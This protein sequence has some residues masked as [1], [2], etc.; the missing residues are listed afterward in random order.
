MKRRMRHTWCGATLAL[1]LLGAGA[2]AAQGHEVQATRMVWN[3][4]TS[5][6]RAE[7]VGF[8]GAGSHQ[9][10]VLSTQGFETGAWVLVQPTGDEASASWQLLQVQ[11]LG[12]QRLELS[13]PLPGRARTAR[14]QVRVL[15][16]SQEPEWSATAWLDTPLEGAR[17]SGGV[18]PVEGWAQQDSQVLIFVDGVE[19][20]RLSVDSTGRFEGT[21]ELPPG[22]GNHQLR[23]VTGT[24]EDWRLQPEPVTLERLAPP[25]APVVLEPV[26]G[27]YTNDTTP[28]IRGTAQSGTKVFVTISGA[29]VGSVDV[30]ASGEW[31]LVLTS[32]LADGTYPV[33]VRAQSVEGETSALVSFSFTV[34]TTRPTV[35]FVG[36]LNGSITGSTTVRARF[37][38]NGEAGTFYCSLDDSEFVRCTS[39]RDLTG[40]AD[41]EHVFRVRMT[42]LAGNESERP[43]EARF[44]VDTTPPVLTIK[45]VPP[46]W[47]RETSTL[48]VLDS[49]EESVD[50][51]CTLD[52]TVVSGCSAATGLFNLSEGPH[53]FKARAIDEV[54]NVGPEVSYTWNVDLTPPAVPVLQQPS[55]GALLNS[56]SLDISGTAEPGSTV[57]VLIGGREGCTATADA[58]G[59]WTCRTTSALTTDSYELDLEVQDV[60]GNINDQFEAISFSVDV[61]KPDTFI[62]LP[63]TFITD[64]A[65][66]VTQNANPTFAFRSNEEGVTFECSVDEAAFGSC[67][68]LANGSR[69]FAPGRYT[70]R[71]RARDRAGNVDDSP[72]TETWVYSIYEGSGGG[73]TGCSASG[74]AP[75]LPLVPLLAFLKRRRQRS[76]SREAAVGGLLALLLVFLAGPARAQG[77]DL[78]QYKPA[79]GS[80]DVLGVYSPQ[81]APGLGL[82]AGLSV[83]YAR[84]PLVLRTASNGDFAQSIVSDQ[85]TADVL[86]SISF[87]DHFELGLAL[88][89]T[90][91]WGPESG[92]LGI[93][94]PQN[95]TGTGLGDLRLVPKAVLPLGALSL[96]LA[97]VVSLPTASDQ[98]FLGAGGVGVQPTLMVQWA[99]SEQLRVLANLGA[100]FQ[101]DKQVALLDLNVGNELTY[102]LGAHWSPAADSKLFVQGN[103]EGAF[104]LSNQ[105]SNPPPLELL[106]AVGYSLPG[107]LAVRLGGGP[108]LT[109]GYGTPNFRLFASIAWSSQPSTP[110]PPDKQEEQAQ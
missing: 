25:P 84:N 83:S 35:S 2:D 76:F 19:S 91:Q 87:L 55:T 24:G 108:G 98:S 75:L 8:H 67:A 20:A 36:A 61:D 65:E 59:L 92:N 23:V 9:V 7:T 80:R 11:G 37:T 6:V 38:G 34:D 89:V 41:G 26:D 95:A 110:T 100:R 93:F 86:A 77:V 101:P 47:S 96:G 3:G 107:G 29:E 82:Y 17:V 5:G 109:S 32:A 27:G 70:L 43:A 52:G 28:L 85:V 15:V 4:Q 63:D 45:E 97:A 99:S 12:E 42:D 72:A 13:R 74:T 88:P 57:N 50:Y 79:P 69:S 18:L 22:P 58:S 103:L 46:I 66:S 68:E 39:P 21:V 78:Q 10:E 1:S 102:A 54:N 33:S 73:L 40:L 16:V 30:P 71:A 60:A 48:I 44:V 51:E 31:S 90:G 106:A 105:G 53:T 81:V 94:I 49:S 14:T 104:A 64:G 56:P 62:D